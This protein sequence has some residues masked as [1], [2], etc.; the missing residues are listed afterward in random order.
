MS[1]KKTAAGMLFAF[2]A[3]S[4]FFV[5]FAQAAPIPI[6]GVVEGFY[7]KPWT[8][9]QRVD[10]MAF[11]ESHG[12][13]AYIYAPKED[14]YH[15]E[16]WREPYSEAQLKKLAQL[17]RE[18]QKHNVRFIFALSPGLDA[19]YALLHGAMDKEKLL[20]KLDAVY[21]LGVRDFAIFFDDITEKDG[22]GQAKLLRWLDESFVKARGDVS[23]L[24]VV[25][26]EYF[27]LDMREANGA[28]K[29]YTKDFSVGLPSD[30]LPLF[31]GDGVAR[32]GLTEKSLDEAAALYGRRIGLW[33]NYPVNDYMETK[34]AL[35]PVEN[36]PKAG[37]IPA[38]FFNPMTFGEMSKIALATGAAY[39]LAPESYEPQAAWE[40]A[41]REQYGQLAPQ[42]EL[43]AD[44]SQHL[45]N[46]WANIGRPDGEKLRAEM[47]EF[48]RVWPKGEGADARL[49]D[50]RQKFGAL[51]DAATILKGKLSGKLKRECKFQLKQLEYLAEA[52]I[53]ALDLMEAIRT[54][55]EK[56]VK[57]LTAKLEKET[58]K[59]TDNE[60]KARISETACSAFLEEAMRYAKEKP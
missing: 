36:L 28:P 1:L 53:I 25:P 46:N 59:I 45:E 20:E 49:A 21:A 50:L 13:N 6:C 43:F 42:M 9:E 4:V 52:D 35:G 40:E 23:P 44:Q 32:G 10:M 16:K 8:Q 3:C 31:T 15:R 51:K 18:A 54:G 58:R 24:L 27:L 55:D 34:L 57:T 14:P 12:L 37:E 41:I 19:S 60:A 39:A 33:W 30:A 22:V 11:C 17:V 48:W 47:D 29:R 56:R 5:A 38:I 26:T 2:F 7:G